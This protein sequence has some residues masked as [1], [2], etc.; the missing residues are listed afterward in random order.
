MRQGGWK[1]VSSKD[2]YIEESF[3]SLIT[4]SRKFNW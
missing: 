2:R 3:P 1:S 4:I